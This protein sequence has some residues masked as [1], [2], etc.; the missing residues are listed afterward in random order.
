[1]Y[2]SPDVKI[3]GPEIEGKIGGEN[4]INGNGPDLNIVTPQKIDGNV[5]VNIDEPK[6]NGV[7]PSV[8]INGAILDGKTDLK[9]NGQKADLP[10]STNDFCLLGI[11]EGKV[12]KNKGNNKININGNVPGINVN[13][14]E[15]NICG[16]IP[17]IKGTKANGDYSN[18]GKIQGINVKGQ[19][20]NVPSG[21]VN[22]NIKGDTINMPNAN[23]N[24]KIDGNIITKEEDNLSGFI[25]GFKSGDAKIEVNGP[26]INSK[27]KESNRY[28]DYDFFLD[29]V[30]PSKNNINNNNNIQYNTPEIKLT[31]KELQDG[32][33]KILS[34]NK[35]IKDSK[36]IDAELGS[37]EIKLINNNPTK[38]KNNIN[39][40]N[41]MGININID[42]GINKPEINLNNLGLNYDEN[43]I[44]DDNKMPLVSFNGDN[45]K[46]RGKGLPSVGVKNSNFQASKIDTA[47]NFDVG[48]I[49][50]DNTKTANVGVNGQKI[51]ERITE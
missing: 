27:D 11:I 6:I 35:E 20:V 4:K 43:D 42:G 3:N 28:P 40:D 17:G 47:G 7:T 45:V 9:L 51:G 31:T 33:F 26:K 48:N 38:L 5:K 32:D 23:I 13:S 14:Q 24:N 37:G 18:I 50:V 12:D 19:N 10:T 30:I 39:I 16:N 8:N 46:R 25:P 41:K 21:N 15:V 36:K 34:K 2:K 44:N 22:V 49:N 29:G 1:M